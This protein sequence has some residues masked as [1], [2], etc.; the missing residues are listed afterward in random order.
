MVRD[1]HGRKMSKSLGNV[2]DPLEVISGITLEG[3]HRRLEQGNLDRNEL[4]IAKA[5]QVKDFPNGIAE[6]GTDALR[7]ALIAYTAQS[8]KINLD[9]Q[10]VVGYRH[11]CNKLWNAIRFAMLNL[12][13]DFMPSEKLN[14]GSLPFGCKWILTGLNKAISKTVTSME[15]YEFSDATSAVYSWWQY[16]LCDVFIEIIKPVMSADDNA[17]SAAIKKATRDTLWVCLDNGL[18]LLHPFMPFVTEELWQRL[19]QRPGDALRKESIMIS[20]YPAVVEEWTDDEVESQMALIELTVRSLRS[21]RMTYLLQPKQ[22]PEA[23]LLC[24]TDEV[25]SVLERCAADICTLATLASVKVLSENEVPQSGC[26]VNVVNERI[27][28]YLLLRGQ[29]DAEVEL[30]KLSKKR[31]DISRQQETLLKKMNIAG[32]NEKVPANIQEENLAKLNKLVAEINIIDEAN[33]NF[34]RLLLDSRK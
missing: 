6:C 5:G 19:P 34:E 28:A 9:I 8:D 11:W 26:V 22:R 33:V 24:K 20:D 23:F 32:Y 12:G 18:R 29:V 1:A 3:L 31:E 2:I 16:Q 13:K 17:T 7:F 27:S 10:R 4:E 21:L 14:F 15:A 30:S 25:A